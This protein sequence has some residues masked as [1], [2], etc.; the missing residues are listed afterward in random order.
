MPGVQIAHRRHEHVVRLALQALAQSGDGMDD[1][2]A[3]SRTEEP[4][5]IKG[6]LF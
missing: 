3:E 5:R 6:R 1:V 4:V 2:H